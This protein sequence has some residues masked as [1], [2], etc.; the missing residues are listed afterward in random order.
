MHMIAAVQVIIVSSGAARMALDGYKCPLRYDL[1]HA[2]LYAARH[3]VSVK[4]VSSI[5]M[6]D[7][8]IVAGAIVAV[9]A[10]RVVVRAGTRS[11]ITGNIV[12]QGDH[13]S[14]FSGENVIIALALFCV[15]L[16]VK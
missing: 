14:T 6:G 5:G 1:P 8:Y 7:H 9:C 3:Q 15:L 4:G 10:T 2:D 12:R 13:C 11:S 16:K